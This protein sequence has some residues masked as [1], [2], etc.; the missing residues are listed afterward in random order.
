LKTYELG[1]AGFS[2]LD[3]LLRRGDHLA[4]ALLRES[5]ANGELITYIPDAIDPNSLSLQ[6]GGLSKTPSDE[7]IGVPLRGLIARHML[8]FQSVFVVELNSLEDPAT[9]RKL[10]SGYGFR[11]F[12]FAPS[13]HRTISS[14]GKQIANL[15]GVYGVLAQGDSNEARIRELIGERRPFA[16]VGVLS[17]LATDALPT[18]GEECGSELFAQLA[19]N[20]QY[21]LGTAYDDE[22]WIVWARNRFTESSRIDGK[23]F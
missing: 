4:Y 8:C 9:I 19:A 21:I 3:L 20:A 7:D 12:T 1:E 17:F 14:E 16:A 23:I 6:D 2:Y 22:G 10:Y 11:W 13:Y 18:N 15:L 5:L